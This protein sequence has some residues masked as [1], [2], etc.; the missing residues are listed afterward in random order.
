MKRNA[1][2]IGAMVLVVLQFAGCSL[3][4]PDTIVGSWQQVSL[5]GVSTTAV[6]KVIEF[7]KTTYTGSILGITT[8]SGIWSKSGD[9]YTMVGVFFGFVAATTTIVPIFSNSDNTMTYVDN[10]GLDEV[11]NRQ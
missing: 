8:N 1:Y 11:Y 2:I 3:L 4:G 5:G 7:T 6:G 10:A 9:S